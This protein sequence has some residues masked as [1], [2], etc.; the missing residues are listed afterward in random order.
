MIYRFTSSFTSLIFFFLYFSSNFVLFSG[1]FSVLS[2]H[3]VIV[4]CLFIVFI[5]PGLL[6]LR[7]LL[8]LYCFRNGLVLFAFFSFSS[9]VSLFCSPP[10]SPHGQRY[11]F[12]SCFSFVYLLFSF[13]PSCFFV[14]FT[15]S[16]PQRT[17]IHVSFL[18]TSCIYL[19]FSFLYHYLRSSL[20][21]SLFIFILLCC[22]VYFPAFPFVFFLVPFFIVISVLIFFLFSVSF[23]FVFFVFILC[24]L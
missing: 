7:S 13:F 14:L 5:I 2:F 3:H 16:F 9:R 15:S 1:L 6:L 4:S 11:T 22:T 8:S 12:H 19:L 23:H 21:L 18:F 20:S 17:G 24:F 10:P